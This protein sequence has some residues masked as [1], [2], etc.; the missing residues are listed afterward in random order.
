MEELQ[1]LKRQEANLLQSGVRS[2]FVL[3]SLTLVCDYLNEKIMKT[4][5]AIQD[6]VDSHTELKRMQ[7]LQ[8]TIPVIGKLSASK[9]LDEIQNVADFRN[10]R[11]LA[12]YAGLTPR[13]FLSGTSAHKKTRLSKTG[14]SNLRK[15]MYRHVFL[16]R[17]CN[18]IMPTF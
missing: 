14:N 10:A 6:H 8:I 13:N 3:S 7:D 12:A 9:L 1:N 2:Y 17:I 4:K 11:Q 15:A 5:T 16:A 18:P